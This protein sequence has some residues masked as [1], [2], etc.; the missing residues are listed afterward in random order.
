MNEVYNFR[1]GDMIYRVESDRPIV[2]I[3]YKTTLK[4]VYY[5]VCA[6]SNDFSDNTG[7]YVTLDHKTPKK[8]FYSAIRNGTITAS[9]AGGTQKRRKIEDFED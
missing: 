6:Q 9:Y 2:G 7:A 8:K 1:V 5:A 4:Y 3:I